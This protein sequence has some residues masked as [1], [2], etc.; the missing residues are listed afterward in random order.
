MLRRLILTLTLAS[1]M[2]APLISPPPAA[3]STITTYPVPSVSATPHFQC[4]D[5]GC[6]ALIGYDYTGDGT[7]ASGCVGW[8]TDPIRV[9][10]TFT[11]TRT[12][13]PSPCKMKSGTGTLDASWP[14]DPITPSAQGTFSFKARHAKTVTFSG[15]ITSSTVPVL[16]PSDPIRGFVTFPP[17]PCTGGTAAAQVSFITG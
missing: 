1:A 2:F 4:T 16:T 17:S 5:F 14:T 7:C 6:G 11:V 12:Y 3:A 15:Q 10:L 9:T 13:P 8:P